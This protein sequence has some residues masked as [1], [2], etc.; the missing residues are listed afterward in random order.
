ER[1]LREATA[2][3]AEKFDLIVAAPG[4]EFTAMLATVYLE[5][6]ALPLLDGA[7]YAR[8]ANHEHVTF[9]APL[10]FGDSWQGAPVVGTTEAFVLHLGGH[11]AEGRVFETIEEAVIGASVALEIGD[12]FEPVHGDG[13]QGLLDAHGFELTA[14]GKLPRTGSPWDRAILVPVEQVWEVHA[15]PNG[16][17]PDWTGRLGPPFDTAHFPGTPAILVSGDALWANYALRSAFNSGE[18]MAFFPGTIIAE[19]HV[20]MG[21]I[22]QVMSVLTLIA[23]GLVVLSVLTGLALLARLLARRLALLRALGAPQRFILALTWSFSTLLII[24]GAACGLILAFASSALISA[25]ITARTGIL[26]EAGL[27]WGEMHMIAG[28]VSAAGLFALLPAFFVSRR[29]PVI[30]L[31][32]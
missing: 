6:T 21:D 13:S 2:R 11:L 24:S 22:Q 17:G 4:S 15:L 12:T 25:T 8:V 30:D 20:I 3:S 5:T 31:R 10:A 27:G 29:S 23:Q 32:G 14:V 9:A 18:T 26:V 1:A 19:L 16:H 28:Y 7:A